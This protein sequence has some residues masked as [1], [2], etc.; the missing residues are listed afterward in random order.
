MHFHSVFVVIIGQLSL[1][2]WHNSIVALIHGMWMGYWDDQGPVGFPNEVR[3]NDYFY[4]RSVCPP[5]FL[6]LLFV[7]ACVWNFVSWRTRTH[8]MLIKELNCKI[9]WKSNGGR[10]KRLKIYRFIFYVSLPSPCI[11]FISYHMSHKKHAN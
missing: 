7:F 3:R 6:L 1:F 11:S 9:F 2:I 5:M 8:L 10:Y 4:T